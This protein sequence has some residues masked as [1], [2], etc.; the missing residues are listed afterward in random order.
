MKVKADYEEGGGEFQKRLK[1]YEH[2]S[3][4]SEDNKYLQK[5]QKEDVN[6]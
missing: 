6:F 1:Q 5:I 3:D 2:S 4:E